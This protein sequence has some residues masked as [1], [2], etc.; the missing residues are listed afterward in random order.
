MEN[1]K[2]VSFSINTKFEQNISKIKNKKKWR[3]LL[4][5]KMKASVT[6]GRYLPIPV[7]SLFTL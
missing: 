5:G 6:N 4:L 7:D 1:T 3:H 2:N